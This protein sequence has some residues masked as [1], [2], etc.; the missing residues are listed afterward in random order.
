MWDM[1]RGI[2]EFIKGPDHRVVCFI[3]QNKLEFKQTSVKS[4][5]PGMGCWVIL[6]ESLGEKRPY[7]GIDYGEIYRY[8]CVV[9]LG[10]LPGGAIFLCRVNKV[11]I[12][13]A[14]FGIG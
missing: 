1:E 14:G 9:V 10:I 7:G 3:K 12:N 11:V 4:I 8:V 2:W 6:A 13:T 5:R